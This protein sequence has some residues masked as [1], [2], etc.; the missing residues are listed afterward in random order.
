MVENN[1]VVDGVESCSKAE[2]DENA[3]VTS[4][5][6]GGDLEEGCFCA[7]LSGS[8]TEIVPTGHWR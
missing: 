3:E 5:R 2:K 8:Q 4:L 7:V 1:G 6:R